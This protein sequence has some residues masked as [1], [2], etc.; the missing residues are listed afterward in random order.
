M[1]LFGT[2]TGTSEWNPNG[3]DA[4][5]NA[6]WE[7]GVRAFS[8]NVGQEVN[9][10]NVFPCWGSMNYWAGNAK[11]Y[12]AAGLVK[13]GYGTGMTPV[14]GLKLIS[15]SAAPENYGWNDIN[16]YKDVAAGK[17]DATWRGVVQAFAG[18]GFKYF[19]IRLAYEYNGSFMEDFMTWDAAGQA[20]WK[21]GWNRAASVM[22]DEAKLQGVRLDMVL[23]PNVM[24]GCP[25]VPS[26][27]PELA[28]WDI[29][30]VDVYNGYWGSGD[31]SSADVRRAFW[32]RP[33]GFGM[34]DAIDL[35][36]KTGKPIFLAECGAGP[37]ANG[38]AHGIGNDA[39]F[40]PWLRRSVDLMR[41]Q[42]VRYWGMCAWDIQPGD[43][44]WRF[45]DGTQPQCLSD[46]RAHAAAFVGDDMMGA[47]AAAAPSPAPA[48]ASASAPVAA[49]SLPVV[50]LGGFGSGDTLTLLMSED[51]YQGDAQFTVK[52]DGKQI[53]GTQTV[54]ASH[55]AGQSQAFI[56]TG[57]F[58]PGPHTVS[59]A[60]LNDAWGGT[61]ATDRNL[62]VNS[63][64]LNG[65]VL[66]GSTLSLQANGSKTFTFT[67]K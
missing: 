27:L 31:V 5:K 12:V 1:K 36:K 29:L 47:I 62:Y 50:H 46:F 67:S 23:N 53:G 37:S 49:A 20:A 39:A 43:G 19:M 11:D 48:S 4:A 2:Y 59:I 15:K 60:F 9:C 17:W 28:N 41:S 10:V 30:G 45:A 22:K 18:T 63:A 56:V 54:T 32:D 38:A 58:P 26:N 16:G 33:G 14:I 6:A 3:K 7:A 34:L 51:A 40:W 52:V 57:R 8:K 65:V 64:S 25:D 24:I 42:G 61:P 35:A 21:A 66:D 13:S 44:S 55:T